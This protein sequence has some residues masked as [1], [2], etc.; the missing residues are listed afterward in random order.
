MVTIAGIA[1]PKKTTVVEAGEGES[2]EA[3]SQLLAVD[4]TKR[5]LRS[6]VLALCQRRAVLLEGPVGCGK[7]SLVEELARLT[8]NR[9]AV[10]IHLDD[11]IDS[12]T[13]MGTYTCTDVPGAETHT[14]ARHHTCPSDTLQR[15]PYHYTPPN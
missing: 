11:Q 12:K 14:R 5:N 15:N 8:G 10:Q 7:T 9:D 4:S 6:A 13:L 3:A 2:G 1:F